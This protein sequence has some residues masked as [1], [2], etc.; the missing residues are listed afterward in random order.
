MPTNFATNEL[1]PPVQ[2]FVTDNG[3]HT[4]CGEQHELVMHTEVVNAHVYVILS[5]DSKI[6]HRIPGAQ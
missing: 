1:L 2:K 6:E 5:H 4:A 3:R